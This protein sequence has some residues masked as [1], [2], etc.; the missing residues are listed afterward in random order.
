M[1]CNNY[2]VQQTQTKNRKLKET[3]MSRK[4]KSVHFVK[5]KLET[6]K[7]N[8]SVIIKKEIYMLLHNTNMI[9]DL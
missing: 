8:L 2:V 9:N 6:D 3:Q 4:L 5:G 7:N 1:N